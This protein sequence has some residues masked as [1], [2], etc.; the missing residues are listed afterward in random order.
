MNVL[1][2]IRNRAKSLKKTVAL[3]EY[4]DERVLQAAEIATRD[5]VAA[6]QLIGDPAIIEQKT[7]SLGL[8]LIH[9]SEPTRPY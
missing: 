1:E 2:E 3:P 6:I 8:S 7:K 5:Q 4:D 9:I